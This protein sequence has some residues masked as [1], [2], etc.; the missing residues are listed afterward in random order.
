MHSISGTRDL[1]RI[2][3]GEL[4]S[5][6]MGLRCVLGV[7]LFTFRSSCCCVSKLEDV[8]MGVMR[9]RRIFC[10]NFRLTFVALLCVCG[11]ATT[12]LYGFRVESEGASRVGTN[13]TVL[14]HANVD[15][16]L[17]LFGSEFTAGAS[18]SFTTYSAMRDEL[19]MHLRSPEPFEIEPTSSPN[20]ALVTV[21]LPLLQGD[22]GPAYFCLKDSQ[23]KTH[24]VHQGTDA[25]VRLLTEEKPVKTTILPIWLQICI[26]IVLLMFSGLF[27]G[28]NLGLMSLDQTEL[29]IMENSGT[30]REKR[31]AKTIRPVRKRGNFLLCTILLGNVLVNNTLAI[32]LDDLTGSG[33]VAVVG[34]T[35]G[36]VI[37]GE[38][39]PQAFCSRYGLAVG[40][41]T[42]WFTKIF[43]VLTFPLSYPISRILDCILGEEIGYVYNRDRLRE[44][45]RIT[46][47]QIDLKKDE[48]S[49]VIN[50]ECHML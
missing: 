1:S 45:L 18:V 46:E 24:F 33:M 47:N 13:S 14:I 49:I 40:A 38:I 29:S 15:V 8:D 17:R 48:V 35:F 42:I 16:V 30:P 21:R 10:G 12:E 50:G 3:D 2:M 7:C 41:R 44:L 6:V 36:I 5:C 31:Y 34:A 37:F 9:S 23:N 43:M 32:L 27:S 39:I 22:D 11:G 28:L 26:V 19:C 25:S 4:G 20:A